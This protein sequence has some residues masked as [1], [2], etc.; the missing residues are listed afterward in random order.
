MLW[1]TSCNMARLPIVGSDDGQWGNLLNDYLSQSHTTDGTLKA[2]SVGTSNIQDNAV[3]TT[4]IPDDAVTA[5]KLATSNNPSNG[6]VLGYNAGAMTW[7][8]PSGGGTGATIFVQSTDPG[9]SAQDGDIWI[10]T[11]A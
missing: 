8:T 11:S 2:N 1:Y 5:A 6:Q 3:S 7:S 10:D 9:V 4:K